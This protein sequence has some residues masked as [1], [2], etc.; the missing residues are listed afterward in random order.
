MEARELRIGNLVKYKGDIHPVTSIDSTINWVYL[1]ENIDC[2]LYSIEPVILTEEWILKFGFEYVDYAGSY[3][4]K[5]HLI[6]ETH[7]GFVFNLFC[8]NDKD[9]IVKI[10]YVHQLQNLYFTLTGEELT[11]TP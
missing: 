9:C 8:S 6:D 10:K 3:C 11:L 5:D 4:Y 2:S 7:E 1:N